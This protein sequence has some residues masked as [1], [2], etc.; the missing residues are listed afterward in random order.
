MKKKLVIITIACVAAMSVAACGSVDGEKSTDSSPSDKQQST[1]IHKTEN[2]AADID[3]NGSADD[4]DDA[5]VHSTEED[6]KPDTTS[7]SEDPV[8]DNTQSNTQSNTETDNASE[9]N[10]ADI[11]VNSEED[12]Q[13]LLMAILGTEDDETGYTYSF[14][15]IDTFTIDGVEY[16][17]YTWS[18]LV[19]GD[20]MS[21]LTDILVQ[22]DGS[23][24][25]QGEYDGENWEI[26]SGNMLES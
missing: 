11:E 13:K 19:D 12:G 16:Y 8:S 24:V 25:Y 23:A 4:Q 15:Y 6:A 5:T 20:H 2:S 7:S 26:N 17:G 21:R 22:T 3:H 10:P 14:G 9:S 18:W 1:E